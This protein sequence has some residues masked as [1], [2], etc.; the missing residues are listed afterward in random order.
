MSVTRLD[1]LIVQDGI[2]I[3]IGV[4]FINHISKE[5]KVVLILFL[6]VHNNFSVIFFFILPGFRLPPE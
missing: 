2:I 6:W 4:G 3:H 5:E 1:N